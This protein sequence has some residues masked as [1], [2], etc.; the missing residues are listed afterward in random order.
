[1]AQLRNAIAA[2]LQ[3]AE[4]INEQLEKKAG[5]KPFCNSLK[6]FKGRKTPLDR[7]T[8]RWVLKGM[9]FNIS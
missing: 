7:S 3:Y 4:E 8:T 2:V 1:M 5:I 6:G 9:G